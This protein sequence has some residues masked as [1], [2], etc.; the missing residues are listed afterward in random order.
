MR[1]V[2]ILLIGVIIAVILVQFLLPLG[3]GGATSDYYPPPIS[4]LRHIFLPW[5]PSSESPG[6]PYPGS[7][8]PA[9]V[10]DGPPLSTLQMPNP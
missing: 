8:Q 5:I 2:L 7:S 3:Y 10:P 4:F 1:D 9:P 6:Y